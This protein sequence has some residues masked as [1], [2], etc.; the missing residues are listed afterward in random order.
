MGTARCPPRHPPT[1]RRGVRRGARNTPS[2]PEPPGGRHRGASR[3]RIL[4]RMQVT[5]SG[6][7]GPAAPVVATR[8]RPG[9]PTRAPRRTEA[10]HAGP[11]GREGQLLLGPRHGAEDGAGRRAYESYADPGPVGPRPGKARLVD[12]PR[13]GRRGW[14]RWIPSWRLVLSLLLIRVAAM[15]A[16]VLV[17]YSRTELP[18]QQNVDTTFQTTI[19]YDTNAQ[20]AGQVLRAEPDLDAA[21]QDPEDRPGRRDRRRGPKLPHEHRGVLHRRRPGGAQQ[22]ARRRP[23]GRLD[24][25]SAV[26]EE[27]LLEHDRPHVRPQDQRVLRLASRPRSRSART[28]SSSAT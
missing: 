14:T 17:A 26:R 12:Y 16:A 28:R 19:V 9:T 1:C 3:P 27:R 18:D 15:C 10:W 21:E 22:P 7:P 8:A 2:G 4:V 5:G 11:T 13:R 24:D 25:H 6:H 20:G 23:P